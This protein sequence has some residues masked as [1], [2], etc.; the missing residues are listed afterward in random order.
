M[1]HRRDRRGRGRLDPSL[2]TTARVGRRQP[3]MIVVA[4]AV[5]LMLWPVGARAASSLLNT[6][7]TDPN[8]ANKARVD[9]SGNLQVAARQSGLWG[10]S[11][12]GTPSVDVANTP[13][14]RS[15]DTTEVIAS[16][17]T[18]IQD[19]AVAGIVSGLDVSGYGEIRFLYESSASSGGL[20]IIVSANGFPLDGFTN[21]EGD[22][23]L[24]DLPGT[25]L[26]ITVSN[27]TN[28]LVRFHWAVVG[29]P[30]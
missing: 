7:I 20:E 3:A 8:G 14:V 22:N 1:M 16:G 6:V 11:I 19:G 23:R 17:S 13:S 9:A 26:T 10:V 29:R 5:A 18:P 4:F 2:S 21:V 30:G 15:A 24:Y 12:S 25:D 28:E 27:L